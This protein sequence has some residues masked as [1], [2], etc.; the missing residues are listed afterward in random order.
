MVR[1]VSDDQVKP[2]HTLH[3]SHEGLHHGK[4]GISAERFSASAPHRDHGFRIYHPEFMHILL[5]KLPAV[6]HD[7]LFSTYFFRNGR[8]A[9]GFSRTSSR[10]SQCVV[11]RRQ[12]VNRR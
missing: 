8:K 9:N 1:F 4:G 6:L 5:Q 7:K 11:V 3:I 2:G 12:G 10:N